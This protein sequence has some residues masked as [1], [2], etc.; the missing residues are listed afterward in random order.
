[1]RYKKF[2]LALAALGL[3]SLLPT[4]TRAD[5]LSFAF[6]PSAYTGSAGSV[7]TLFGT[8][9]NGANPITFAGFAESL[10]AGLSLAP[11]AQP[12]DALI[13]L[14]GGETLGPI[15]L[16]NVL[17]DAGTADGTV[18][19]FAGN[20]FTVFYDPTA[21]GPDQ[22]AA[23]FSITVRSGGP[24]PVPEPA[25]IFLLGTGLAGLAAGVR[26]RWRG[27]KV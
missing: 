6:T 22:A 8:F 19:T 12:F 23:N 10:E 1:M 3:L 21:G 15:A 20:Q 13:G 2:I 4:A 5:N 7:V 11:G 14:T 9:Q 25:S 17:I 24:N 26:K 27:S 18:F 16:F